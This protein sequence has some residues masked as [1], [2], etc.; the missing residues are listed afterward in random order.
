MKIT[1]GWK[2][3]ELTPAELMQAHEEYELEC[4]MEDVR[5][6]WVH[7]E[8]VCNLTDEQVEEIAQRAMRNLSRNDGYFESYWLTIEYTL[9]E[10]VENLAAENK[11]GRHI[12]IVGELED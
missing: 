12:E 6:K 4:M 11:G 8:H 3:F 9:D 7:S 2:E 10:Y 5:D 1:R